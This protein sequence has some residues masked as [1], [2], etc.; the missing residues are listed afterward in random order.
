METQTKLRHYSTFNSVLA[1]MVGMVGYKINNN[2]LFWGIVDGLFYPIALIKWIVYGELT[3]TLIKST[4][5][6]FFE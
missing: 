6:F 5:P 4:F 1:V 2:S 3:S